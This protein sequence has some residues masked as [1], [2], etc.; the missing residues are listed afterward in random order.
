[1]GHPLRQ[2]RTGPRLSRGRRRRTSRIFALTLGSLPLASVA[3]GLVG[4]DARETKAPDASKTER[5]KDTGAAGL[6]SAPQGPQGGTLAANEAPFVLF[7]VHGGLVP[8]FCSDGSTVTGGD[9]GGCGAAIAEGQSVALLTG[10]TA[11]IVAP[12]ELG[13]GTESTYAAHAVVP[14]PANESI[15]ATWPPSAAPSV[16]L[17]PDSYPIAEHELAAMTKLVADDVAGRYAGPPKLTWTSGITAD[18]DGDSKL[19]RVVAA[20]EP[21]MLIGLVVFFPGGHDSNG[22][23]T[24]RVLSMMQFDRPRVLARASLD[25]RPGEEIVI[26]AA[27]VEGIEDQTVTSAVST[28]VVAWD[29]A[30]GIVLGSWG[31]RMF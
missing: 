31:C 24:P 16:E 7:A 13:C 2:T 15:L 8:L 22:S 25:G 1:M 20:H 5:G 11:T 28:R 9:D 14:E 17:A 26:D 27:F 29:G 21:D 4:C 6:P 10:A 19:D 12:V 30:E 18:V 23:A 3:T